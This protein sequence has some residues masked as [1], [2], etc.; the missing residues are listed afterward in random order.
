MQFNL[1]DVDTL[2]VTTSLRAVNPLTDMAGMLEWA[3]P[4]ND[5]AMIGVAP[6]ATTSLPSNGPRSAYCCSVFDNTVAHGFHAAAA[7]Q[8]AMDS[9]IAFRRLVMLSDQSLLCAQAPFRVF[10]S[11]LD[12]PTI[13]LIGVIDTR[14]RSHEWS[15]NTSQLFTAGLPVTD[16]EKPPPVLRDD[17]LLFSS[18]FCAWLQATNRWKSVDPAAWVG[19]YGSYIS[20]VAQM[21]DFH[22]IGWGTD[23]KPLPPLYLA[24][25][26]DVVPPQLL[27]LQMVSVFSPL[28]R[29]VGYGEQNLRDIFA[30]S[31]GQRPSAA[32]NK[33]QPIILSREGADLPQ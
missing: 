17:V 16:W 27:N 7:V 24:C 14:R 10:E 21:S 25:S 12:Q 26:E 6:Q 8:A 23:T 9:G 22:A 33:N 15:M 31:R 19:S 29:V 28:N 32:V 11:Q 30:V 13:G 18:Q 4:K 1:P 2:I 20:W 3:M 5:W